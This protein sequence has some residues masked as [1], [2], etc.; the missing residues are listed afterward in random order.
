MDR[1]ISIDLLNSYIT[2]DLI[3]VL[4]HPLVLSD[5]NDPPQC[6]EIL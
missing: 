2:K 4:Y 6:Y 5:M 3:E 1:A